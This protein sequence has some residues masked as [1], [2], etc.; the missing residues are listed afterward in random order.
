DRNRSAVRRLRPYGQRCYRARLRTLIGGGHSVRTAQ[1]RTCLSFVRHGENHHEDRRTVHLTVAVRPIHRCGKPVDGA[2]SPRGPRFPTARVP[3]CTGAMQAGVG[4]ATV[5]ETVDYTTAWH[6]A[7]ADLLEEVESPQRRAY[8]TLT[9]IRGIH[10]DTA[11]LA[12]PDT[13]LRDV[14]QSQ[15]RTPLTQALPPPPRP[16]PHPP[17]LP[18][19]PPPP[20]PPNPLTD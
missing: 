8:L 12:V 2:G 18:P 4:R 17:P 20:P 3:S 11:L 9:T 15:L 19:A 6:A 7:L 1:Y 13:F 5:T 14:I 10:D 16:A